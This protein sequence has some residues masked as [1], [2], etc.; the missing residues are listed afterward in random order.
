LIRSSLIT[1]RE[2]PVPE[3]EKAG[4]AH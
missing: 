2:N 3:P 1:L 4:C